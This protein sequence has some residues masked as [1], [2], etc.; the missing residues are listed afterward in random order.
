[1]STQDERG[2]ASLSMKR[3]MTSEEN[4]PLDLTQWEMVDA[5][6]YRT[7]ND[8]K[9][10]LKVEAPSGWSQDAVNVVAS[11]YLKKSSLINDG[12]GETSIR[13]LISRVVN[14]ISE[15]GIS[16]GYFDEQNGKIFRD[17]LCHVL[18]N[19]M[20]AFNSPVYFNCGIMEAYGVPGTNVSNHFW[21]QKLGKVSETTNY[22]EHP[23]LSACFIQSI[24]DNLQDIWE[25]VGR[26][27]KIYKG[28]SGSGTNFSSLRSEGESL[29]TGGSS[30]GVISFLEIFDKAAGSTKSG[31]TSRRAAKMVILDAG[32]PEITEFIRWKAREEEKA[33]MLIA[34][35]L[36]SDFNGEAYRTVSGQN[37][38][39]TVRLT[40][41]FMESLMR[42][43]TWDLKSVTTG[44]TVRT[45]KSEELFKEI[46][47]A[48]WQCADPGLQFDTTINSWHTCPKSGRINASNPCSEY[49]FLDDSACNLASINLVKFILP[50]G[51]FDVDSFK[52]VCRI[53]T[54]AQDIII[55]YASYPT[56]MICKNSH[57]FRP[58]GL[59]FSN[60]GSMLM[61]MAIPYDS[62]RGRAIASTITAI[63]TA[64]S[65]GMSSEMA[66]V[67]GPFASFKQNRTAMMSVIS[68]HARK[69][70]NPTYEKMCPEYLMDAAAE[71]WDETM[72]LGKKFGF[73]NA[74]TTLL[75][76][77]GTISFMMDCDTT[78]IEPEYALVKEKMYSG[79]GRDKFV[80]RS[81]EPALIKLGYDQ[82]QIDDISTHINGTGRIRKYGDGAV[83]ETR[84]ISLG[85]DD[86]IIARI[87]ERIKGSRSIGDAMS[88]I[89]EVMAVVSN[90]QTRFNV[91]VDED[92]DPLERIGFS[93]EEIDEANIYSC[94]HM[95]IETA[96]HL[97]PEHLPIF[98]C[99]A[100]CGVDGT[101]VIEAQGHVKMMAAAQS[102]MGRCSGLR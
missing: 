44:E 60:L 63:M 45:M 93:K 47:D 89:P 94:G 25:H 67:I 9:D 74:Q 72:S 37:S 70:T 77:T 31:G 97:R 85:F 41:E 16:Q 53:F 34:A 57:S 26:E 81:V 18:V 73:R 27:M 66:E 22:F 4:D 20:G 83:C 68:K 82:S 46:C 100:A 29:S 50:D 59:G 65:Y 58:I 30:S 52:H 56:E 92:A 95:G 71:M 40:D 7:G 51:S 61:R 96:P 75:A 101:R 23:Q 24:K 80:N 79:G 42:G 88:N 8:T 1:M 84:L 15:Q 55:D 49:T 91:D 90:I 87:N 5:R 62:D 21:D 36:P 39:N 10:I 102:N 78:G 54:I 76:P 19:Q 12:V 17:E 64:A 14:T 48:A 43:G 3:V 99:A 6:A 86:E 33:K 98:D 11:K 38:N 32:H 2:Q 35:G 28:G 13:A 69:A